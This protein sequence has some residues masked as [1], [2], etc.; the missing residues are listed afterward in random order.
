MKRDGH[1]ECQASA[2]FAEAKEDF[3]NLIEEGDLVN[4]E[5]VCMY[6]FGLEPDYLD[7]FL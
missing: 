4:A 5:E 1:S 3:D 2:L 7:D 6:H